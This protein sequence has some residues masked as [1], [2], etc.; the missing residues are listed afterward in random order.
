MFFFDGI[1]FAGGTHVCCGPFGV[2]SHAQTSKPA[3]TASMKITG[4]TEAMLVGQFLYGHGPRP[5]FARLI[6]ARLMKGGLKIAASTGM[7]I[8]MARMYIF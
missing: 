6:T 5:R 2:K 8:S 3:T 1:D 4:N 7:I